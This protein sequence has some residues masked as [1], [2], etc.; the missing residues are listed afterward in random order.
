MKLMQA[1]FPGQC[2]KCPTRIVPGDWIQY[3]PGIGAKHDVCPKPSAEILAAFAAPTPKVDASAVVEFL[4]KA[5][6]HLQRPKVR[7]VSPEQTEGTLALAGG[8][9]KHPGAIQVKVGGSWVGRINWDGRV[10]GP[11]LLQSKL[12]AVV[13]EVAADPAGSARKYAA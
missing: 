8:D 1:K 13:Q 2:Q 5:K 10:E 6:I 9:T 12:I 11:I 7:F 3:A 4:S